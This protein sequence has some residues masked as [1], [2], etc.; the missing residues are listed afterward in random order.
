MAKKKTKMSRGKAAPRKAARKSAKKAVS[1]RARK[2]KS[3]AVGGKRPPTRA[4][5]KAVKKSAKKT[6]KKASAGSASARPTRA[7]AAAAPAARRAAQ[8]AMGMAAAAAAPAATDPIA[9]LR[10]IRDYL[11][12]NRAQLRQACTDDAQRN[13]VD[14]ALADAVANHTRALAG[15]FEAN[16]ARVQDLSNQI[17]QAH[18]QIDQLLVNEENIANLINLLSAV[19]QTGAQL[20]ALAA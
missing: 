1:S 4:A 5:K 9:S 8:P 20:A 18:A 6:T 15:A 13:A 16:D 19:V 17:D 10:R 7:V 2:G 11:N 14:D 3:K 12:Q